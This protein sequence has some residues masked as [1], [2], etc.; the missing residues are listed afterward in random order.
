MGQSVER[1]T[2]QESL[3]VTDW[4]RRRCCNTDWDCP[5]TW[6]TTGQAP[7][8]VEGLT[9][10]WL[11]C[12]ECDRS[13]K[14]GLMGGCLGRFG[15]GHRRKKRRRA[16]RTADVDGTKRSGSPGSQHIYLQFLKT[17]RRKTRKK[18]KRRKQEE[19][20]KDHKRQPK[21]KDFQFCCFGQLWC[22]C[23]CRNTVKLSV[24]YRA[25]DIPSPLIFSIKKEVPRN[26]FYF[27]VKSKCWKSNRDVCL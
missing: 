12:T 27:L 6:I 8:G 25:W 26:A 5:R 24:A 9:V 21:I 4:S 14:S 22:H 1:T 7:G 18:I 13:S 19:K 17:C 3:Q 11:P 10:W 23:R 20:V 15:Y 2:L 16:M